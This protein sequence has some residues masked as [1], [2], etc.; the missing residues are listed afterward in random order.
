MIEEK[1][2]INGKV[3]NLLRESVAQRLEQCPGKAKFV[4]SNPTAVLFMMV[5]NFELKLWQLNL[6]MHCNSMGLETGG[7]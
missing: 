6:R 2:T 7:R 4:G 3:Y 1:V 5:K